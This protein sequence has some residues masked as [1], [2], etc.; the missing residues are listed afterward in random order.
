MMAQ[1]QASK[2]SVRSKTSAF[3]G[4]M[5]GQGTVRDRSVRIT[6]TTIPSRGRRCS[7]LI[8]LT[9]NRR[10]GAQPPIAL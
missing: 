1:Q 4:K 10:F 3:F 9:E 6:T 5:L 7:T 2:N 8:M